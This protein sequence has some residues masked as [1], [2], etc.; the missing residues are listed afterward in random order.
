MPFS[1]YS[2]PFTLSPWKK[3]WHPLTSGFWLQCDIV[4]SAFFPGSNYSA[5][6]TG[7]NWLQLRS[8]GIQTQHLGD[9]TIFYPFSSALL[10]PKV[11]ALIRVCSCSAQPAQTTV[12]DVTITLPLSLSASLAQPATSEAENWSQRGSTKNCSSSNGSLRLAPKVTL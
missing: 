8:A 5:V 9:Q 12:K 7:I 3:N 2:H 1:R 11:D 10:V 4:Q 6:V